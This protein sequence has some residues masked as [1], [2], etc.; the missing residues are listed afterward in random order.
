MLPSDSVAG[1]RVH[2]VGFATSAALV[3]VAFVGAA[4]AGTLSTVGPYLL[5]ISVLIA[6]LFVGGF[7]LE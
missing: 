3:A 5:G 6:V 4:T 2:T 7:W 1:T